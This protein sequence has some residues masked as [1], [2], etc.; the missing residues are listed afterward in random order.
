MSWW[1]GYADRILGDKD[2]LTGAKPGGLSRRVYNLLI[3]GIVTASLVIIG[4][5]CVCIYAAPG[6]LSFVHTYAPF[7]VVVVIVGALVG[8]VIFASGVVN[9]GGN[10]IAV[11]IGYG[12]LLLLMGLT[13][14][15][16]VVEEC[17]SLYSATGILGTIGVDIAIIIIFAILGFIR[18]SISKR[19]LAVCFWSLAVALII[20]LAMI[21]LFDAHR[22]WVDR[23][24][25]A[26]VCGFIGWNLHLA[27]ND[28]ST[29]QNAFWYSFVTVVCFRVFCF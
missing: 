20:E 10:I 21:L 26:M 4:L 17:C 16:S 22:T 13:A 11:V 29:V 23:A 14:A 5:M 27:N 2:L 15:W 9:T 25:N 19:L 8:I 18:P 28:E 7:L 6:V 1:Y 24:A 12:I 3:G